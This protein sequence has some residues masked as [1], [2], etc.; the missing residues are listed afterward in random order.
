[1]IRCLF[2]QI[3]LHIG[4]P[5]IQRRIGRLTSSRFR[6]QVILQSIRGFVDCLGFVGNPFIQFVVSCFTACHFVVV[7]SSQRCNA[8]GCVLVHLLDDCILGLVSPDA[9]GS[10]FGQ[11]GVQ[12]GHVFADGLAGF[13]DGPILY[14]GIGLA[15][16]L[17]G[18]LLFQIFLH[19]G[20]AGI[21]F[22]R[23]AIRSV[24]GINFYR[25]TGSRRVDLRGIRRKRRPSHRD[26]AEEQGQSRSGLCHFFPTHGPASVLGLAFGQFGNHHVHTPCFVPDHLVDLVHKATPLFL[27]KPF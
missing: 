16:I 24:F 3:L 19:I 12:V 10:F 25:R 22:S 7:G 5:G 17:V 26:N 21:Q 9:G 27:F 18:S 6:I 4:D 2:F 11:G 1:M 20:D 15:H 14:G 23:F 13:Y 8:I